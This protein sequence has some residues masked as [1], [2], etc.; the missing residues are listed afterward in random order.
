[1]LAFPSADGKL[2][3]GHAVRQDWDEVDDRRSPTPSLEMGHGDRGD[4]IGRHSPIELSLQVVD[5]PL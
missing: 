5:Q 4:L 1:M 2:G 3:L